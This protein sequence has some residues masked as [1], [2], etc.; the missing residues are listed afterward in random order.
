MTRLALIALAV[1]LSSAAASAGTYTHRSAN[2]ITTSTT[3][4][5]NVYGLTCYDTVSPNAFTGN[6]ARVIEMPADAVRAPADWA[7]NCSTSCVK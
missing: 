4:H 2:G 3:C 7:K 6:S 5:Y 1:L